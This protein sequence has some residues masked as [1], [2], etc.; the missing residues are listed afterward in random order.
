MSTLEVTP[1]PIILNDL[2]AKLN[3]RAA[4]SNPARSIRSPEP[5]AGSR[6]RRGV[7]ELRALAADGARLCDEGDAFAIAAWAA[8]N[9]PGTLAVASSMADAV[10]P[11]LVSGKA[12]GVDVLFLDTGLHFPET[13]ATRDLV[14]ARLPVNVVT[15]HPL[16]SVAEQAAEYGAELQLRDPGTCCRLRKVE[17]L[18][19]AL[20]GYEAWVTGLRRDETQRAPLHQRSVSTSGISW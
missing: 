3:L 11:H 12:P 1:K 5:A 18:A 20:G 17:P 9:F 10:L 13:L 2:S 7:A 16:Q 14:A 15:V 8:A 6:P 19:R 4:L